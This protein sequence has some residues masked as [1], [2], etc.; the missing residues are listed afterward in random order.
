[1]SSSGGH[2]GSPVYSPNVMN[3]AV[4]SPY[5]LDSG[6]HQYSPSYAG[7]GSRKVTSGHSPAPTPSLVGHSPASPSYSPPHAS[8]LGSH[9]RSNANSPAYSPSLAKLGG[10][11]HTSPNYS[12]TGTHYGVSGPYQVKQN[13]YSPSYSPTTAA[14]FGVQGIPISPKYAV[15]SRISPKYSVSPSD[16][17]V[18]SHLQSPALGMK[19]SGGSSHHGGDNYNDS[20]DRSTPY[21]PSL[22]RYNPPGTNSPAYNSRGGSSDYN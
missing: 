3:S 8:G 22:P 12:P 1:M 19:G 20:V 2:S 14:R 11:S 4:N 6:R 13:T 9:H 16:P 21:V 7:P 18:S 5:N 10:M 15:S 17:Q